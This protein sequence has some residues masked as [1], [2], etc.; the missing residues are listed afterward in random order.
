MAQLKLEVIQ[1]ALEGFENQ[2]R[3]ID[4]QIAE[5]RSMLN[6]NS[7]ASNTPAKRKGRKMSAEGRARIA[8][9][10]KRRWAAA[11]VETESAPGPRSKAKRKLSVEGRA[12]I[13]AAL[14]KRWAAKRAGSKAAGPKRAKPTKR[15]PAKN[16][17]TKTAAASS[18]TA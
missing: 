4:E 8:E 17:T 10:Q 2:K 9:A 13:I 18:I 11:R 5:L 1:A 14:K 15:A 16:A 6:G 12:A 7:A 3:R